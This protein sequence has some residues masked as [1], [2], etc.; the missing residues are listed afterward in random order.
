ME[1][2]IVVPTVNVFELHVV[3]IEPDP[4][5]YR[6]AIVVGDPIPSSCLLS[7]IEV[8][9]G[10]SPRAEDKIVRFS[11]TWKGWLIDNKAKFSQY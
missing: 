4:R 2:K 9:R 1:G 3:C 11:I 6:L 5:S 8:E 7:F 10:L